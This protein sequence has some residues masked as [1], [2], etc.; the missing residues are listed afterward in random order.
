LLPGQQRL[1]EGETPVRLGSRA[2]EILATLVERPGE[3]VSKD[4]LIARAWPNTTVADG[5]LKVHI[6]ALRKALGE[7]KLGD[8]YVATVPGRGYRFVAAVELVEPAMLPRSVRASA[9]G[10]PRH[11][12]PPAT[13]RTIGRAETI[14]ALREQLARHR[15]V[16]IV[17]PGGIGKTTVALS[18]AEAVIST[19]EH[20]VRFVDLAPLSDPRFVAGAV[21]SA[22]GLTVFTEDPVGSVTSYL[23]DKRM[24]VILDNCEHVIEAAALV[25]EQVFCGAP[26]VHIRTTSREPLGVRGEWVH[27]LSPLASPPASSG[28][29]FAEALKFPAVQLFMERAAAN[30]DCLQLNDTDAPIVAEI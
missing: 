12:L 18:A 10:E 30:L 22:L 11:N 1:L 8:R 2:L 9:T 17:G 23:R 7:D 15:L 6:A 28:L 19:Y 3:L 29:T 21:A 5:N 25:A 16:S 24:L 20:G 26:D 4:E 27:R 14:D 13:T